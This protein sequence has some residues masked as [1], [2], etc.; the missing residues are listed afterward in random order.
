MAE[1]N[2]TAPKLSINELKYIVMEGGGARGATYLGA[3]RELENQLRERVKKNSPKES[4][5]PLIGRDEGIMD[6]LIAKGETQEDENEETKPIIEGVAGASAGAIT[7]FALVLGLNSDEI[8]EVL[9]F[10]FEKFL[11]E[12]DV[13]KYRMIDEKSQLAIG[14]DEK[15]DKAIEHSTWRFRKAK[16]LG[17]KNDKFV[18]NLKKDNTQIP[19]NFGKYAKREL[20]VGTFLKI[21]ID[22][23]GYNIGQFMKLFSGNS[24]EDNWYQRLMKFLFGNHQEGS[25]AAQTATAFATRAIYSTGLTAGLYLYFNIKSK[26]IKVNANT[27]MGIFQDRGMFSGFQ[28]R[29][30]FFDLMIYAATKNTYFQKRLITF[31]NDKKNSEKYSEVPLEIFALGLEQKD[32]ESTNTLKT[33]F[34]IGERSKYGFSVKFEKLLNHLQHLTFRE[35]YNIMGEVEYAAAVSNFTTNSPLYF[36]DKYTPNARVLEAVASS[37]SIPPAIRPVYN[38]SDVL[39]SSRSPSE[40]NT[41]SS[42]IIKDENIRLINKEMNIWVR[43][44]S[45]R[46]NGEPKPFVKVEGDKISFKK[47]DYEL[48]E[49]AFKKGFQQYLLNR[50]KGAKVYI[51][52]NN[53]LEINTF[54]DE[55]QKLLIGIRP[56]ESRE[57]VS[58]WTNQDVNVNGDT[59]TITLD[60]MKFFYNAQFKG[61][62]LD[63]GYFN[64]IPFNFFREKGVPNQIEGVLPIKLDGHFPPDFL[65]SLDQSIPKF[66]VKVDDVI[67]QIEREEFVEAFSVA[68]QKLALDTGE[69]I[70]LQPIYQFIAL[71]FNVQINQKSKKEIRLQKETIRKI[72]KE[73]YKYYG[74]QNNLKPWEIPRPIIDIAFTGYSYGAKRG[75][76]RDISD[77]N[78]II[79]LYD[80]GIGTYDF[81]MS[82]VQTLVDLAQHYAQVAVK[83]YFE[84]P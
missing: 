77:H 75:Q 72:I 71:Q 38:A 13:G 1:D 16:G 83:K 24:E 68:G 46:V 44:L 3:I 31:F 14:Q 70:D 78:N 82:K 57:S 69:K 29:E 41:N 20:T 45:V 59:Y 73:W 67:K 27:V 62:L 76:I 2:K 28:V 47:S 35:F 74:A 63:G 84:E 80:Y 8:K 9:D 60:L 34:K 58:E 65:H 55:M 19:D 52:T 21:I 51:D 66:K 7:T 39:L 17:L 81:D 53:L 26:K 37:M 15:I 11:S 79:P 54:L 49:Y 4:I 50:D 23:V 33:A 10:P 18:Y 61:L 25:I 64:N 32:F 43:G 5:A 22:G 48:Y 40:N 12:V 36:S 30:F 42:Q 56:N 6:F